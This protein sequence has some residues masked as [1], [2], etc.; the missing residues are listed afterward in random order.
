MSEEKDIQDEAP[1]EAP[2]VEGAEVEET[3]LDDVSGGQTSTS[4]GFVQISPGPQ[5][6]VNYP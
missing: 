6:A 3:D 1:Q 5:A 2:Q 4:R